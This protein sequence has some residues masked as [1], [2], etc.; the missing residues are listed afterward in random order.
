MDHANNTHT[1]FNGKLFVERQF[2]QMII[3]L[4]SSNAYPQRTVA[5]LSVIR[6]R[7]MFTVVS[8]IRKA[9]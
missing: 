5:V 9:L 7:Q 2:G 4:V 1:A 8:K 6:Y 3:K